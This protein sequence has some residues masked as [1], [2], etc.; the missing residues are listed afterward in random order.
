MKI[1]MLVWNLS[2]NSLGRTYPIAKV[3]SRKHDVEVIGPVFGEGIFE[4]YKDEFEYKAVK[5]SILAPFALAKFPQLLSSIDGDLV[6]AFKPAPTSFGLGLL[7]KLSS[8]KKLILDIEDWDSAQLTHGNHFGKLDL[9]SRLYRIDSRLY[10]RLLEHMTC[11]ADDIVVVSDFL[12]KRFGG[13]KVYH[14]VDTDVLDPK[15]F[16]RK[17]ERSKYGLKEEK[18]VLFSGT[19]HPHKGIDV[20]VE[21]I[22][23]LGRN[24]VVLLIAGPK[25]EHLHKLCKQPFVRYVGMVPHTEIG[26]L[27]SASDIVCLPQLDTPVARAQVPAKVFEAMGMEKAIIATDVGE[28][29]MILEGCGKIVKAGDSKAL[30]RGLADIIEDDIQAIGK[31]ARKI[32]IEDFSF[33]NM[34]GKLDTII[35]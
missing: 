28:L 16:D 23:S 10:F 34:G 25:N 3:L 14:G 15:K 9:I 30:S 5:S 22:K 2:S 26:G 19:I 35:N 8:K 4:P 29:P 33:T 27:L 32:C 13:I 17:T 21:A 31:K 1:S 7:K 12:Q 18:V 20:L 6:Y 11:Y 24:D